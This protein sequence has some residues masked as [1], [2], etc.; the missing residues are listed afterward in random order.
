MPG[1]GPPSVHCKCL[2]GLL[3]KTT[4]LSVLYPALGLEIT[5]LPIKHENGLMAGENRKI[6]WRK[7]RSIT[8]FG[9]AIDDGT[10]E[11]EE[12]IRRTGKPLEA[13]D[14]VIIGMDQLGFVY[15]GISNKKYWTRDNGKRCGDRHG[16]QGGFYMRHPLAR[17]TQWALCGEKCDVT[18]EKVGEAYNERCKLLKAREY[19]ENPKDT[20]S[21]VRPLME[22]GLNQWVAPILEHLKSLYPIESEVV[23][24]CIPPIRYILQGSV[25]IDNSPLLDLRE[26]GFYKT[27]HVSLVT[28]IQDLVHNNEVVVKDAYTG[29]VWT[30]LHLVASLVSTSFGPAAFG[31]QNWW[32]FGALNIPPHDK[33][34]R[35]ISIS[36]PLFLK[37]DGDID[38]VD[39]G[40]PDRTSAI[41]CAG[42]L[43]EPHFDYYGIPQL[44]TH[45]FGRKLWFIWPATRKNLEVVAPFL[46]SDER[47][48]KLT[49]GFALENLE[50]LNLTYCT[51]QNDAFVLGPYA[52]HA[53]ISETACGHVNKLFT[54]YS[55][56]QEWLDTH[57]ILVG[58][59]VESCKLAG[60]DP[61][62]REVYQLEEGCKS[63]LHWDSLLKRKP[64]HPSAPYT[65]SQLMAIR[66][67]VKTHISSLS[68]QAVQVQVGRKRKR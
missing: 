2:N 63:F 28:L 20:L 31:K 14:L 55:I 6:T 23:K 53:V 27:R 65:K 56:F 29:G 35:A 51:K 32:I 57:S 47:S 4:H 60:N 54:K 11:L 36:T 46:L 34:S 66:N 62:S 24:Q 45:V 3:F 61:A 59:L 15:N 16:V 64:N 50:G 21:P 49:I 52:I 22:T 67:E 19:D 33:G 41:T 68:P 1:G 30:A 48:E 38:D 26:Q 9:Q 5:P 7:C 10:V 18:W 39:G 8:R 58:M 25:A 17:F 37:E 44:V 43:T 12:A 42:Y 40:Y 13:G